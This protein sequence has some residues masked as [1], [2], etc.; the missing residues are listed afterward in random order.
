MD[1]ALLTGGG[2]NV[3]EM[4]VGGGISLEAL[5]DGTGMA[6]DAAGSNSAA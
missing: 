4:D 5:D 1:E 3:V 6:D 2:Y